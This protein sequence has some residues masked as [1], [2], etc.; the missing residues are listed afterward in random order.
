MTGTGG[1]GGDVLASFVVSSLLFVSYD[2]FV[3]PI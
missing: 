3:K 2:F 1:G